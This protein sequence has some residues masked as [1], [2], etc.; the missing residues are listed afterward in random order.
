MKIPLLY[1]DRRLEGNTSL[2]Q[3]Q[4]ITLHLLEVFKKICDDHNLRFWLAHGTLLGALRHG[5][6]IPWDDDV[7]VWITAEDYKL[8]LKFAKEELPDD[9]YLELPTDELSYRQENNLTRLRDNYSIGLLHH[10]KRLLI[11]D[12][13]GVNIELFVL[14]E[15]GGRNKLVSW[16]LHKYMS[17][18]GWY[19]RAHYDRVTLFNLICKWLWGVRVAA[20]CLAWRL[21]QLLAF[22]KDYFLQTN[23]YTAWKWW[24]P[25]DWFVRDG[26]RSR[27]VKYEG[28][29]MPIP[30]EAEKFLEMQYGNWHQLPPEEKRKG[31]LWVI[32]PT[33]PCMHPAAM[34]YPTDGK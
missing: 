34:P 25:R 26:Q 29:E 11:N 12:H 21:S 3:S 23:F 30:F 32:M 28:V 14:E 9:V 27:M 1:K 18:R 5:G 24:M 4:L 13:H 7:D 8:F 6:A 10:N 31:Y 19:R 22:R 16:I 2:R 17:N 33:T 20:P 15:C